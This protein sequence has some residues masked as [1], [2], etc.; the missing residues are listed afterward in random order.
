ELLAREGP[1]RVPPLEAI[2]RAAGV[3]KQTIYRWWS[4]RAELLV[5]AMV[6]QARE[7]VITPKAGDLHAR[8]EAFLLATFRNGRHRAV[9]NALRAVMADAQRDADSAAVLARFTA[10]RRLALRAIFEQD[11][12]VRCTQAKLDLI[13]D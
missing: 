8:V 1:R 2:A 6:E 10:D 12:S 9:A 3:G 5:D 4:S 7:R 13:V 11:S